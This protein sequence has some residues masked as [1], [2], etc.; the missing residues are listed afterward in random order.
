MSRLLFHQQMLAIARP[1]VSYRLPW[2]K[3]VIT[4]DSH[5]ERVRQNYSG[6]KG[7]LM[8]P[9]DF[10]REDWAWFFPAT[11]VYRNHYEVIQNQPVDAGARLKISKQLQTTTADQYNYHFQIL[12]Q[13]FAMGSLEKA[14]LSRVVLNN[15][16]TGADAPQL[17]EEMLKTY[18]GAMVYL[19]CLPDGSC[20]MGASP[21][22]LLQMEGEYAYTT[23]VAAT[24]GNHQ[25]G[26]TSWTPKE[27]E[28]Q[29]IVTDYILDL[30]AKLHIHDV[31]TQGPST[32]KAGNVWHLRTNFAFPAAALKRKVDDFLRSLHP[33]PAVCGMPKEQAYN[34]IKQTEGHKREFYAG[35]LGPVQM[36]NSLHL[37]VNLRCMQLLQ[38]KVAIYTGGGITADSE[39]QAE[40]NET[41][42][43]AQTMLNVI[44]KV[45]EGS[46][47]QTK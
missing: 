8:A 46:C 42:Q 45:Q 18:P 20:W 19:A 43:K 9:Y 13:A 17:F 34:V 5:P 41:K 23:S 30:F 6:R 39:V 22:L 12:Q 28:E 25:A 10:S 31:Q 44:H 40:W 36:H 2:G 33:T 1:F 26:N 15:E 4:I 11:K 47:I 29:Q 14:V 21:E 38:D 35:F 32:Y 7:F 16:S 3:E 27:L 37:F 24:R